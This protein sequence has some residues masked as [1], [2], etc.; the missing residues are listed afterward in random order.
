MIFPE[1][2]ARYSWLVVA[3]V[4][5]VVAKVVVRKARLAQLAKK[6]NTEPI[7]NHKSILH[8]LP[9]LF[10]HRE[11]TRSG[12]FLEKTFDKFAMSGAN[13]LSLSIPNSSGLILTMNPENMK[14]MLSTQF[15]EF[16][17][18]VRKQAFG[19]LLGNGIFASEGH[20]WKHSRTLL[21]PQFVREQ[22]SHVKML[23]PHVQMLAKHI[24]ANS[25]Y[26][27]IQSLFHRFT[28]D[29]GTHFLFGES[30]NDLRDEAIGY[31]S[32]ESHIEGR[33][34]FNSALTFVQSYLVKRSSLFDFYWLANSKEF[35][36]SVKDI[37]SYT[38]NFVNKA[39]QLKPEEIEARSRQGY[40]F[41]YELVKD[42]RDPVEIRD[43]LL[44]I[45]LA[46]RST[47]A[48]LL[49]SA[50]SELS[51]NPEVWKKLREEVLMQFGTG[52]SPEELES[53]TFES[54]KKCNY[55]KWVINETLRVY[56]PVS[57]N[58]REALRDTTLPSG[59]GKDGQAPILVPKG[60]AVIISI[61]CVQRSRKHYGE[62]A[63]LFR[64][65]RWANLNK[66]GWAFMPFGSGPRICLGQQ[67]ALTE[68][69]Y[70]LVRLVQ[71]FSSLESDGSPY[72]A[73]KEANATLRY[74]DGVNV[75]M[76]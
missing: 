4:L 57:S 53:I 34:E 51:R 7:V 62:D 26:F 64:P 66:I 22:V 16:S 5:L 38:N 68:A 56:P 50:L 43:Q 3:L 8:T 15:T 72:P 6:W 14:A 41:L 29:A 31:D 65:E 23:E 69:S 70:V 39:L 32:S 59:G 25:G 49:S 76:S 13:T 12:F 37:H 20:H 9:E 75:K 46:G 73:R 11:L 19:P 60:T 35:R 36:Q 61:Y 33:A 18:G 2:F 44:N 21:K 55:L 71:M 67:F 58:L 1:F 45:M 42:T 17:I 47:T 74:T 40:T 54:L 63:D 52:E 30:V 27:D 24:R 48:S 28:L 10:N